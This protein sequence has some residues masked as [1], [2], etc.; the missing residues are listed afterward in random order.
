MTNQE[1]G[2]IQKFKTLLARRL[3]GYE[4]IAFGSRARGEAD[5]DSDLD[6]LVI[7]EEPFNEATEDFVSHCAWEVGFEAGIVVS[8]IVVSRKEWQEGPQQASLLALAIRNEGIA[9]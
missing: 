4:V 7:I 3:T 5:E 6:I 1:M 2:L 8:S 9:V